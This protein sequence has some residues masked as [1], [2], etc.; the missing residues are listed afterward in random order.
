VKRTLVDTSGGLVDAVVGCRSW[1]WTA[2]A[3]V[4]A[5]YSIFM[6]EIVWPNRG[7]LKS[8]CECFSRNPS[9]Q[10]PVVFA[11]WSHPC[12]CGIYAWKTPHPA[13][14]ALRLVHGEV[15][16]WGDVHEHEFGYRAEYA[17]PLSLFVDDLMSD[18]A[19]LR[20]ELAALEYG[21]PLVNMRAEDHYDFYATA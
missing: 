6:R 9:R 14:P 4:V 15:A 21:V 19:R 12:T 3:G 7:P 18:A 1:V 16:L 5:L 2:E 8:K 13:A 10:R 20:A 11:D 17:Q